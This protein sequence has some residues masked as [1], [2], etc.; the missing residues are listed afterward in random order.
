MSLLFGF[1]SASPWVEFARQFGGGIDRGVKTHSGTCA[2]GGACTMAE[3]TNEEKR[4]VGISAAISR[5]G[6][7]PK[8][9]A[10]EALGDISKLA[11]LTVWQARRL[12]PISAPLD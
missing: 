10:M 1:E 6:I 5:L 11:G 4:G 3:S 7:G 2:L 9:R 12:A 8:A